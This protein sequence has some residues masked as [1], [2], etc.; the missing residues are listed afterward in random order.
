MYV[1]QKPIWMLL[2]RNHN[3]DNRAQFEHNPNILPRMPFSA[4]RFVMVIIII[5][6][7]DIHHPT[8]L[9]GRRH[10]GESL[11]NPGSPGTRSTLLAVR[12]GTVIIVWT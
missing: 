7:S 2:G 5:I 4:K 10:N 1:L 6:N 8:S 12:V 9:L 11:K 3:N